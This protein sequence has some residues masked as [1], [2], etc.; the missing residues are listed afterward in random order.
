MKRRKKIKQMLHRPWTADKRFFEPSDG[1]PVFKI[2]PCIWCSTTQP[3]SGPFSCVTKSSSIVLLRY[4]ACEFSIKSK[5]ACVW[6]MWSVLPSLAQLTLVRFL[7]TTALW[8]DLFHVYFYDETGT[9]RVELHL[10]VF[11]F[12][13]NMIWVFTF[14]YRKMK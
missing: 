3:I 7:H 6:E 5:Q 11:F 9:E 12:L 1:N 8:Y 14:H 13:R 4:K 2:R 10:N